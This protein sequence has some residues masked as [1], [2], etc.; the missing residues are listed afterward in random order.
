M[1]VDG[2]ETNREIVEELTYHGKSLPIAPES[3]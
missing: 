3:E 2:I 1:T